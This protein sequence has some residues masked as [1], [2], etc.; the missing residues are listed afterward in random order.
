MSAKQATLLLLI[1]KEFYCLARTVNAH[2]VSMKGNKVLQ[3][4]A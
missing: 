1:H 4:F 2:E 3:T